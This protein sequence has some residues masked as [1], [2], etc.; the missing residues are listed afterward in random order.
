[1][2]LLEREEILGASDLPTAT[3]AVP[4]WGGEVIVKTMM[5]AERDAWEAANVKG[6]GK[7]A[8]LEMVNIRARLAAATVVDEA[9]ALLFKQAD[10]EA[11]GAKSAAAVDRIFAVAMTLNG[12]SDKDLEE[13]EKN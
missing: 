1:M 12:L 5:A 9:G 4:E 2:A 7:H 10:V 6:R 8:R 3:V 11:L 13:L